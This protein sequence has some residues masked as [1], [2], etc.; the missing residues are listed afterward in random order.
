MELQKPLVLTLNQLAFLKAIVNH[1]PWTKTDL[2]KIM[3]E[4]ISD[5]L[6]IGIKKSND[7]ASKYE[8][9]VEEPTGKNNE[10]GTPI[11]QKIKKIPQEKTNEYQEEAANVE[12]EI[13]FCSLILPAL[14][15]AV[16]NFPNVLVHKDW[17]KWLRGYE[18]ISMYESVKELFK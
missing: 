5:A 16:E 9:E 12:I 17:S 2:A 14:K 3:F 15:M 1:T 7:L 13:D 4:K 10:D 6:E 8:E 11:M 18:D